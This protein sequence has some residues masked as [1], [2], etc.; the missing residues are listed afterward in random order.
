MDLRR[1]LPAEKLRVDEKFQGAFGSE[2][3]PLG[4]QWRESC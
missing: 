4:V 1:K 3:W 2:A